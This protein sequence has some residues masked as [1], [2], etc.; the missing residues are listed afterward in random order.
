MA[1]AKNL[2]IDDNVEA[3]DLI[4]ISDV[5][6]RSASRNTTPV[7]LGNYYKKTG[8]ADPVIRDYIW[9]RS[10]PADESTRTGIEFVGG[11]VGPIAYSAVTEIIV[12]KTDVNNVSQGY[13]LSTLANGQ[14][15]QLNTAGNDSVSY[16][17]YE[18][19]TA[20]DFATNN[21]FLRLVLT[22][23]GGGGTDT[24]LNGQFIVLSTMSSGS[25][26]SGNSFI[27]TG[28]EGGV[29]FTSRSGVVSA[30]ANVTQLRT[31]VDGKLMQPAGNPNVNS[32]V[33]VDPAGVESYVAAQTS[34][35]SH[36]VFTPVLNGGAPQ[37]I[38]NFDNT[39]NLTLTSV[40]GFTYVW[41]TQSDTDLNLPTGWTAAKSSSL[42]TLTI[43]TPPSTIALVN[44]T[45][46]P[47]VTSTHTVDGTTAVHRLSVNLST[48]E[49]YFTGQFTADPATSVQ[50]SLLS[51]T[52]TRL[53]SGTVLTFTPPTV[54]TIEYA[55]VNIHS[56][57][58][59]P[60]FH[61][62][63]FL[64][65]PDVYAGSG[66]FTTYVIPFRRTLRLEITN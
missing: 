65:G 20:E 23:D 61:A 12:A 31:D 19:D 30:V 8:G 6:N 29:D 62:S 41:D 52:N 45:I 54:G 5:A 14:K 43:A 47:T 57:F 10:T 9:V 28:T 13:K 39:W 26:G 33:Q 15:I 55:V 24:I 58:G 18:I 42:Q 37:A 25:G 2:R 27:D 35:V 60:V 40:Q 53:A 32:F 49:T 17:I 38:G 21:D 50:N 22:Y 51:T 3:G 4:F 63:G 66:G 56:S 1:R 7:Y 46:T 44:E 64:I 16:G 36:A 34:N 48:F 59:T 11:G